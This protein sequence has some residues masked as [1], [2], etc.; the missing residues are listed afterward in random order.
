MTSEPIPSPSTAVNNAHNVLLIFDA[1]SVLASNPDPSQDAA[2]PTR[3]TDGLVFFIT[4]NNSKKNVTNDSK[5][6]LPV[7]IGRDLHF[8]GR[9]VS[10]IAE[11]SVVI[12]SMTVG[13]SAV[14]T[15]PLLEVHPGVTVPA[16]DPSHP[17]TPGSHKADDHYWAC[18]T[19]ASGTAKCVLNFMLVDQQCETA[20]YFQWQVAIELTPQG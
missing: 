11:H 3:I 8:R 6:T 5:L 12:Y 17:T 2:N 15:D 4:G 18:T 10:L 19:K 7:E 9:S 13:N 16:P 1:E 20:G 14:L